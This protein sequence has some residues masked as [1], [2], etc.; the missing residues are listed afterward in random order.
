MMLRRAIC[1]SRKG[2]VKLKYFLLDDVMNKIKS[3]HM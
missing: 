3:L 1:I 2:K